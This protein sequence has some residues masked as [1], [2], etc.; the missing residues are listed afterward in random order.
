M[1]FLQRAR[2]QGAE[3]LNPVPTAKGVQGGTLPMLRR[4]LLG[5]EERVPKPALAPF[6]VDA[7]VYAAPPAGGLR[8]TWLGHS[9]VLLE[10]DGRRILTDPMWAGYASPVSFGFGRRFFP[11]P[12]ALAELPPLDLIIQSHDHYDHLDPATLRQ[13][14]RLQ[15]AVPV[16]CPLRVGRYY[17]AA[18]WNPQ[19]IHELDWTDSFRLD[20]LTVTAVPARHFSGRGIT[21]QNQ[22]LWASYVLQGPAHRVFFGG[23]TGPFLAGHQE[24]GAAYGP[25]DLTMLEVGAYGEGWPDIHLGPENAVQAHQALRG[26]VL[27]PIHWGTF[28]LAFHSW[29]EPVEQ[30]QALA[31]AAGIPLL[32]P[33]PGR[34]TEV[35]PAG[36]SSRWWERS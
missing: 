29:R 25:F 27:L 9:T 15:P 3:F 1:S 21:G 11:V 24:I 30:V 12:L 6:R 20:E 8:V 22:T 34:P 33:T 14:A 26:R 2:L 36:F 10:L 28:N 35:E 7:R 18:G 23:D 32:L 16:L 31:A 13:L 17:A 5:A 19:L 4:L